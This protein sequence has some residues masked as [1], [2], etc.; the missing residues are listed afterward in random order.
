MTR[1]FQ[2]K[3]DERERKKLCKMALWAKTTRGNAEKEAKT[4]NFTRLY[5]DKKKIKKYLKK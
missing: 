2:E 5:R 1:I 4:V 3:S